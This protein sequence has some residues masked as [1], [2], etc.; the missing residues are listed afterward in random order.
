[1][2]TKRRKPAAATD[3][4]GV[5]VDEGRVA[6]Q[7]A[8]R[9]EPQSEKFTYRYT[10]RA[11]L[12]LVVGILLAVVSISIPLSRYTGGRFLA[13]ALTPST[14]PPGFV[15]W[16]FISLVSAL[17]ALARMLTPPNMYLFRNTMSH[18]HTAQIHAAAQLR[19]ADEL[20]R[21]SG[22]AAGMGDGEAIPAV[23]LAR[24]I[25][26]Q[27]ASAAAATLEADG[28]CEAV[29]GRLSR[30]LRALSSYGIFAES[31]PGSDAWR[32]TAASDF[33]RAD[34][35][36]SLRAVALTFG[37]PQFRMMEHL[38]EAVVSG[39]SAF[40]AAHGGDALWT[41]YDA[42]PEQR[43]IFD[44]TMVQLGNVG[45]ADEAIAADVPWRA[46]AGAGLV[47]VGGGYGHLLRRI[48]V[49]G[50]GGQAKR[51]ASPAS[52]NAGAV[53]GNDAAA[54]RHLH[55]PGF[56]VDLPLTAAQAM[57][58]QHTAEV[59]S[60]L[61]SMRSEQGRSGAASSSSLHPRRA[62]LAALPDAANEP[63]VADMDSSI[64]SDSD[65]DVGSAVDKNAAA[66]AHS[67]TAASKGR[68]LPLTFAAGD[69]FDA[70]TLPS[71]A[72]DAW[73][74]RALA[75]AA[76]AVGR[77]GY[78]GVVSAL[79]FCSHEGLVLDL[80]VLGTSS[81]SGSSSSSRTISET[82]AAEVAAAVVAARA[83]KL[84]SHDV[85][86]MVAAEAAAQQAAADAAMAAALQPNLQ[87]NA[88]AP[89]SQ[90]PQVPKVPAPAMP[91]PI[92][93]GGAGAAA[94]VGDLDVSS[95]SSS[96]I[97][98]LGSRLSSVAALASSFSGLTSS[99]SSG[100]GS[101]SSGSSGLEAGI[102]F[103]LRDVLHDWA[104]Q[105]SAAILRS[106]RA[107]LRTQPASQQRCAFAVPA[108]AAAAAVGEA[109][110][111]VQIA[112]ATIPAATPGS[113]GDVVPRDR[114]LLVDRL[115]RP[116][117][118]FIQSFGTADADTVM[119]AAFG[120]TAGERTQAQF[121]TLLQQAGLQ[122]ERVWPTRSHYV[123]IEA[124]AKV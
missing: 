39:R 119:L 113:P 81:G 54:A 30:L 33:L 44:D 69:F 118:G 51:Q 4:D 14:L 71:L 104:D 5:A 31:S 120:T 100:S 20:Y 82:H 52:A 9:V 103:M 73:L 94:G 109:S 70:S 57:R 115:V 85:R 114:V 65:S 106:L 29:A 61:H 91:L 75:G 66:A 2:A 110:T 97:S 72:S 12:M 1:M 36:H 13:P 112:V 6:L 37:G 93:L 121:A 105:P 88:S 21:L 19:I 111:D 45:G 76:A 98:N 64:D 41:W 122:L 22:A 28:S 95:I 38:G 23:A 68:L 80:D 62:E 96:S 123:V 15:F 63:F 87:P 50:M 77:R 56:V 34:S 55:W 84:T 32:N 58:E 43:A 18:L 7:A 53:V 48:I 35:P 42:R 16:P 60:L 49:T 102:A 25:A 27:C 107:A 108:A 90:V 117:A 59:R 46:I 11:T 26:P 79:R 99:G 67:G 116:G 89:G 8:V 92:F 83:A 24:A 86:L 78:S 17:D 3:G 74:Q 101:G 40:A 10:C 47:D 124:S